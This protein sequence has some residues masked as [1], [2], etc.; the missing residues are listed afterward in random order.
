[1]REEKP[2]MIVVVFA[3]IFFILV[4]VWGIFNVYTAFFPNDWNCKIVGIRGVASVPGNCIKFY[5]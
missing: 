2:P 1:M 3:A 4:F 5:K